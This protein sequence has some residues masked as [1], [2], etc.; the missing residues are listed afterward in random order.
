MFF[1]SINDDEQ[2]KD[3]RDSWN[4]AWEDANIG[5]KLFHDFDLKGKKVRLV[6]VKVSNL[7][8]SSTKDSLF[9][10]NFEQ[11]QE[12]IHKAVDKIKGKFGNQAIYRAGSIH[13]APD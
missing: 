10:G 13:Q 5:K 12:K 9:D 6:G 7:I 11:K 4:N 8:S 2:I 1:S 3:F